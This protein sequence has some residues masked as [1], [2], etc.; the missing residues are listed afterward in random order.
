MHP[1]GPSLA[2][3]QP[4]SRNLQSNRRKPPEELLPL[5][6]PLPLLQAEHP[7]YDLGPEVSARAEALFQEMVGRG[8]QPNEVAFHTLMDV[9]ASAPKT[10]NLMQR[11][12]V[13]TVEE[14]G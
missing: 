2:G 12:V 11:K 14:K 10:A 8:V 4:A 1:A 5:P 9:Q 7:P 6:L 13:S 3:S